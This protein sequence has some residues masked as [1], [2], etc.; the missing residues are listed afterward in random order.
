MD[1]ECL[2]TLDEEREVTIRDLSTELRGRMDSGGGLGIVEVGSSA[3]KDSDRCNLSVEWSETI[4][5]WRGD[6]EDMNLADVAIA[7]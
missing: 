7:L 1:G 4:E 3:I 6:W 2:L 5:D